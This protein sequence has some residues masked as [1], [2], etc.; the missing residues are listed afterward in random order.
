MDLQLAGRVVIITGGASG[1]GRAT[2]GY[3]QREG[4]RLVL[5]DLQPAALATAVAEL[6]AAGYTSDNLV[7]KSFRLQVMSSRAPFFNMSE[8]WPPAIGLTS[9]TRLRL[10]ITARLTRMKPAS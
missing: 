8:K 4:A 10:T 2:A 3:F 9:F 7:R 1:I 6:R 5:A